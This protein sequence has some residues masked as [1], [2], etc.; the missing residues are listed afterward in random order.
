MIVECARCARAQDGDEDCC[1]YCGFDPVN[2]PTRFG[3]FEIEE[4]QGRG[5]MSVVFKAYRDDERVALKVLESTD[6][7]LR[8]Q[9]GREADLVGDLD[10]P[11]LVEVYESGEIDEH[12]YIAMEFVDGPTLSLLIR[13]RA[14]DAAG[15]A[16]IVCD[17]A[18]GLHVAHRAGVVHRDITP[19]N[20]LLT[21]AGMPKLADFGLAIRWDG[22]TKLAPGVTAG[23]PV[24]MSPEQGAGLHDIVDPRADIYSLAAVLFEAVA[25]RPP[26]LGN[27]TLD[28]LRKVQSEEPTLPPG[29]DPELAAI[30][31]RAMSKNPAM[32]YPSMLE[33]ANALSSWSGVKK[34]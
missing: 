20:I 6:P 24:Y 29:V 7:A 27:T 2:D 16:R 14:R 3:P 23:T 26:F 1:P 8:E 4:V 33:F 30:I 31:R 10:H 25:G 5:A 34:A 11:N 9:F 21:S 15:F 13:Q 19:G 18:R 32:R 12:G 17:A 22:T 28:I